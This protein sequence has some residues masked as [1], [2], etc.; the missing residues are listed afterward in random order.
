TMVTLGLW[1]LMT[2]IMP[3]TRASS[4]GSPGMSLP[5]TTSPLAVAG[6]FLMISVATDSPSATLSLATSVVT[7]LP[8]RGAASIATTGTPWL[9]ACWVGWL[10]TSGAVVM[11]AIPSWDVCAAAWNCC[12]SCAGSIPF[13][14][15]SL[16][17]TPNFWAAALEPFAISW[18]AFW[19]VLA[20]TVASLMSLW[21]V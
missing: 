15:S 4:S 5:T 16:R 10:K 2:L 17:L 9:V 21:F 3:W 19:V 11:Y 20:V 6:I 12:T 13:G 1:A 7:P 18:K 8:G 14:A